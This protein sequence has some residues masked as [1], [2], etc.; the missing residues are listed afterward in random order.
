MTEEKTKKKR[1]VK[2][3]AERMA[4][5]RDK[6]LAEHKALIDKR[7]EIER[8]IKDLEVAL[9]LRTAG[10]VAAATGATKQ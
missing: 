5:A 3:A 10:P 6:G 7:A 1:E 8:Q 4:A 2:T 9:G